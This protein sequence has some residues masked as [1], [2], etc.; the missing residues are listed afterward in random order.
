MYIKNWDE[1][2][3]RARNLYMAA[4]M[5]TRYCI[6]YNHSGS[7]LVVKVTDDEKVRSI[8]YLIL[9]SVQDWKWRCVHQ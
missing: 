6:K 7:K 3:Q 4:P 8:V 5:R 9:N 1:F 2:S